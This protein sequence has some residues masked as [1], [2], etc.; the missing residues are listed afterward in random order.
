[1]SLLTLGLILATAVL[2]FHSPRAGLVATLTLGLFMLLLWQQDRP[3]SPLLWLPWLL[4]LTWSLKPLRLIV[5]TLPVMKLVQRLL[6]P[7]SDTEREALAAGTTWWDADLFSG[8]PQ[9][10]K[11]L[12][13][14]RPRL[15][16]DEQAFLNG[17][18]EALCAML[19]DW[20][21]TH[22][23]R[24]L[25]PSVWQFMRE[26]G[27]FGL[28]IPR[29]YGGQGFSAQAHSAIVSK[30]GSRSVSAAITVMVPNSLGP[31]ELLLHYGT[32]EQRRHY[33]P[34]L[35]RGED[36]PCFALTGPEAGSDASALP[37]T[38]HVCR[39][40]H[41]GQ[42]VLGVRLSWNKRYITL[43]PVATVIGLAFRLHDPDHLLG[44]A[45]DIGIT[46]ALIPSSHPGVEIGRRHSPANQAFMN[47]PTRGR[48]VFIPLSW[49]IG[50]R[51]Q[52]GHGW[53]MLMN[54]LAAGR[55]ISLPAMGT[56]AA[57]MMAR[58][59]AEY[60]AIRQQFNVPI[61][62]LEGV[63]EVVAR[64]AGHAYT[65]EAA[66]RL[67][68]I[69]LDLGEQPS[70]ISAMMK[71]ACTERMREAVN[72]AMDLHAGKGIC[73]GPRNYLSP[74]Y[75]AVPVGI[76]VEGANILTRSL[77]IFGQG[78]MRCHPHLLREIEIIGLKDR[79]HAE[80]AFDEVFTAHMRD[81]TSNG[82]R[83]FAHSLTYS[84]FARAPQTPTAYWFR[85]LARLSAAFAFTADAALGLLGGELK[86]REKLSG[87]FADAL[88]ELYL[89]SAVLKRW[90]DEG[91]PADDRV[92]VDYC[93]AHSTHIIESRL[94]EIL[95]NFPSQPVGI[96]LRVFLFPLGRQR[97]APSDRQGHA[98]ARL[99]QR[100]SDT[101]ERLSAGLFMSRNRHDA[102][103]ALEHA[104]RLVS[105]SHPLT[106]RLKEAV[107]AGHLTDTTPEAGLKAGILTAAEAQLLREAAIAVREVIAVDD[108]SNEELS[109][110][111]TTAARRFVAA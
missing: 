16:L 21:I 54:A 93:L 10:Q 64:L 7:I 98:V 108:F 55:G 30:I 51:A 94:F 31:A 68:C 14:P 106:R 19:D 86:R 34:R 2:M 43:A 66:R 25:P 49:I 70:V 75:Q 88:T 56:T 104:F 59:S 42:E 101:L 24:D 8:H 61:A 100:P 45:D 72:D 80:E 111:R 103:G 63:E 82:L 87:R 47:G 32:D 102:T 78:A 109:G 76:T 26:Q 60:T 71:Y 105:E 62:K 17:P 99:L 35:A 22:E 6:P 27:F 41:E 15:S 1:M 3:A 48:D 107:T 95:L 13:L 67:T 53:S 92:L 20:E 50:G 36:I 46:L 18:T 91:R 65:L 5:I 77:I 74:I 52:A 110:E 89:A 83:A 81:L 69:G 44:S 23:R 38:G 90:E 39:G 11:L 96:L 40:L 4:L 9:W 28:I 85:Q 12:A 37:D 33:L 73:E 29:E 84:A 79:H 58:V 57:K 97:H